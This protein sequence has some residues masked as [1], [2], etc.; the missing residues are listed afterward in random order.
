MICFGHM[1]DGNLHYNITQP[2][3]ADTTVFLQ[4]WSKM[5]HHIHSLV[6]DYRGAFSAE[7]GIGQLKREE[8]RS[9]KSPVALD[10]MQGIKKRSIL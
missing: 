5:N 10:I 9:F 3:G 2:V 1:G 6:M 7:H 4:L 8:L